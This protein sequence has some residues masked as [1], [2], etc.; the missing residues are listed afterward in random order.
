MAQ[1]STTLRNNRAAQIEATIGASPTLE[2]S[3]GLPP[4]NC[5]AANTGTT[6]ASLTLPADWAA[7]PSGG[8]VTLLGTWQDL[9]ADA[10]GYAGH[11]RLKASGV[12]H[13]QGI[14]AQNWAATTAYALNQH[15]SNG[16]NTYRCTTAGTSAGAGGPTGTGVGIADGTAVF[17]YVGPSEMIMDN[18]NLATGQ[19]FT[20][21]AFT[22]TEGG[23]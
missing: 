23:A 20:V 3:S 1:M 13:Y 22:S 10:S 14:C 18:T 17:S 6:L 12:C 11:W 19:Q 2:I 16:G 8:A 5:A 9:S 21:T 4:A 7:A 15:V